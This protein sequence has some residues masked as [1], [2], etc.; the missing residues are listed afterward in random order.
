MVKSS[1][2]RPGAKLLGAVIFLTQLIPVT[3]PA[4]WND[5]I[6]I[7]AA[8]ALVK[9]C[10]TDSPE[11]SSSFAASRSPC[12]AQLMQSLRLKG[13]GPKRQ[14][15]KEDGQEPD[16]A[17]KKRARLSSASQ[18]YEDDQK[19][20]NE[21]AANAEAQGDEPADGE[22]RTKYRGVTQ[23]KTG[24]FAAVFKKKM[25]GLYDDAKHAALAY[26][27]TVLRETQAKAQRT[28]PIINFRASTTVWQRE[29][30][31]G[32]DPLEDISRS[33]E[34]LDQVLGDFTASSGG[35]AARGRWR[36]LQE[37]MNLVRPEGLGSQ[38]AYSKWLHE[39]REKDPS[40]R[41]AL[42]L[43]F[44]HVCLFACWPG[45]IGALCRTISDVCF[46]P[47]QCVNHSC[48]R[49]QQDP[50]H[51]CIHAYANTFTKDSAIV[52]IPAIHAAA[53][54]F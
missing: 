15:G 1:K 12:F 21:E 27:L 17:G 8:T 18:K 47:A 34:I 40:V 33:C 4:Q 5:V 3:R 20:P 52:H 9:V 2:T 38:R 48:P 16:A 39:R 32:R 41:L 31:A 50:H 19:D 46:Q 54:L 49:I 14:R 28:S 11:R 44:L 35:T 24:K 22:A 10:D 23:R 30:E 42:F 25:I 45:L 13:G 7:H 36:P 6:P 26:D 53:M 43:P 51:T 29:S 37:L